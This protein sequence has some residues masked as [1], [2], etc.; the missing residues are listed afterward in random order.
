M[1]RIQEHYI[2]FI[3][4][5]PTYCNLHVVRECYANYGTKSRL[6]FGKVHG[7]NVTFTST[8]LNDIVGTTIDTNP[9]VLMG[10]NI[11]PPY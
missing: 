9:L 4:A 3:F 8:I 5:E 1:R 10:M 11:R 2:E 7:V 6:H